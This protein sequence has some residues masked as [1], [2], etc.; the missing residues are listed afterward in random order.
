MGFVGNFLKFKEFCNIAFGD[1]HDL[2]FSMIQKLN[3]NFQ[4][5]VFIMFLKEN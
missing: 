1:L 5:K 3:Q 4:T 2:I